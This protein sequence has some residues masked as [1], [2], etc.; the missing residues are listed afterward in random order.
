MRIAFMTTDE[1]I[2]SAFLKFKSINKMTAFEITKDWKYQKILN[3]FVFFLFPGIMQVQIITNTVVAITITT[4]TTTAVT[5]MQRKWHFSMIITNITV[6]IMY[7]NLRAVLHILVIIPIAVMATH[8]TLR[9]IHHHHHHLKHR[10][11][12]HQPHPTCPSI[13]WPIATTTPKTT[14]THVRVPPNSDPHLYQSTTIEAIIMATTI[15]IRGKTTFKSFFEI[16]L[17]LISNLPKKKTWR[18]SNNLLFSLVP[19]A[20]NRR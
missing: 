6:D 2:K 12:K 17:N 15:I 11:H 1:Q 9:P 8:Q 10:R 4:T 5:T 3:V 14:T 19:F 13:D 7:K 18:N 20:G 16:L